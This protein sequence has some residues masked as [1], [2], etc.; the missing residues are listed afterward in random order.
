MAKKPE[1]STP[2]I[3]KVYKIA[4]KAVWLGAVRQ[5]NARVG[6][7]NAGKVMLLFS[8]SLRVAWGGHA[9]GLACSQAVQML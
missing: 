7:A 6:D 9:A 2:L 4:S 8:V 1:P 3:S 5:Q